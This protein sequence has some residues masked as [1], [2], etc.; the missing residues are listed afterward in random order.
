[1]EYIRNMG[2]EKS[3]HGRNKKIIRK[4]YWG[5]IVII[6]DENWLN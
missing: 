2:R 6:V 5:M 3:T 1:M 4:P